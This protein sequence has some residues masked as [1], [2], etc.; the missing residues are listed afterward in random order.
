MPRAHRRLP[1][2]DNPDPQPPTACALYP[3][4]P[5]FLQMPPW[6]STFPFLVNVMK[7]GPGQPRYT[8]IINN[9]FCLDTQDDLIF[10]PPDLSVSTGRLA[11][12]AS[13]LGVVLG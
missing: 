7:D 3:G 6:S 8:Q 9:T 11:R 13:G 5:G 4:Y 2:P 12:L 10:D 1:H